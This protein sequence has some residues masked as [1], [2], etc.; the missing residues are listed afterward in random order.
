MIPKVGEVYKW[1]T[2]DRNE[3]EHYLIF[4]IYKVL[5]LTKSFV[6]LVRLVSL[7]PSASQNPATRPAA[8]SLPLN[9][10][11]WILVKSYK[12]VLKELL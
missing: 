7:A 12:Q 8:I 10:N 4:A 11:D 1:K 3:A 2:L 9:P 6:R 5:S